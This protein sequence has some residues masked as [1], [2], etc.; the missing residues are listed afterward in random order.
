MSLKV[1]LG[2]TKVM[3]IAKDGMPKS[4]VDSCGIC[5]LRVKASSVFFAM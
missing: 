5:S 4:K 2:K 3:V 1:A